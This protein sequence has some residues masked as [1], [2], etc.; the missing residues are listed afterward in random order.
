MGFSLFFFVLSFVAAAV[1]NCYKL[2]CNSRMWLEMAL[3]PSLLY[4]YGCPS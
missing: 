3:P 2:I 4:D 1:V